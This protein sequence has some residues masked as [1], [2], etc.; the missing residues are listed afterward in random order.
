M[1]AAHKFSVFFRTFAFLLPEPIS[2]IAKSIDNKGLKS[3]NV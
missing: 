3:D 1:L 2:K